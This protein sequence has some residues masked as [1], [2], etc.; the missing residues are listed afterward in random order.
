MDTIKKAM[1]EAMRKSLGRVK[2]AC[3]KVD[4]A[5][6]T[7][8]AW[9]KDDLEYKEAIE[10]VGEEAIDYVE[11]KLFELIDGPT[12]DILTEDGPQ[13]VKDAP[14]ATACIF[15]LKTKGKKRGYVER[16]EITGSDDGPVKIEILGNI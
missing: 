5:R 2:D 4:I 13:T 14:N 3:E 8:Y 11:S 1:I 16:Q 9:M 15:Y 10:A 7:H 12:R 6:S